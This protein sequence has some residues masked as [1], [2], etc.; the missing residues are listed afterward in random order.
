MTRAR[1]L[2]AGAVRVPRERADGRRIRGAAGVSGTDAP[3]E[4]GVKARLAGWA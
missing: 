1:L 2:L 3:P 4:N